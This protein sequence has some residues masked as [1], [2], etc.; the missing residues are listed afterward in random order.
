MYDLPALIQ[1]E[2]LVAELLGCVERGEPVARIREAKIKLTCRCNLRCRFCSFGRM[3]PVEEITPTEVGDLLTQ[4]AA[5]DCR[6]VHFSGGE[7]T[8]LPELPDLVR[9]AA[10]LGMR[11]SLT[12]NATLL[13]GES[14]EALVS[15][16]LR[17]VSV[18]LD[19]P[20]P[21][22]HD[23]LRGVKG[24]FKLTGAG[25]RHLTRARKRLKAKLALRINMVLT[26]HNYHA[27]P[28]VLQLAAELGA[29]DV[30]PIPVDERAT[31]ENRLLPWQL[32]EF[33]DCIAPAA[34]ALRAEHGFSTDRHLVYPFG[35]TD[36]ELALS[37]Q[38]HY[39]LGY[40]GRHLC[41]APW[42]TTLV[43]WTGDVLLCCMSRNKVAPVGNVRQTPLAEIYMGEAYEQLRRQFR[44]RRPAICKRCDDFLAE[45]RFLNEALGRG[46]G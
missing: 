26:R 20:E 23:G 37:A 29:T 42:L 24:A 21:S 11:V 30:K 2:G 8:L 9:Q 10:G 36:D 15:A 28:E 43:T 40:Y 17:S 19:G 7:A 44:Q 46:G 5:M 18:S 33:N 38:Q 13:T 6:K 12:T 22:V 3:E 45:N 25:I 1:D 34:E 39:G 35:V 31:N 27:Y 4:L 14:A 16:G 41:F 32:R